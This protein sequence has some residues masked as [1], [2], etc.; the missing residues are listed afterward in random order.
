[1]KKFR[2]VVLL[3]VA[4]FSIFALVGCGNN[5]SKEKTVKIGIMTSDAPIWEPIKTKLAK[6]NINLKITEF[7]DFNQPNQALSQGELDIN[8]FQHKYFLNNWNK[9]HNTNLV[10]IGTTVIAPLRVYS[11]K[12]KSIN[13]LKSGDK[14]TIPNDA[15]NE[16]RAL[17]LLETAGL[18]KLKK[19]ALPTVKDISQYN[20][21]ITITPLDAAQ[22][23][24]SLND[25]TAAVVN[26]T[27]AASA[28]LPS[29][30]VIYKE[31]ITKKSDQWLNIIATDKKNK[32]NPTFKKVVK[33]Y[34]SKDNAKNIKK[35]YKGTT[36]PAWDLKL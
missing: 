18:I 31:K 32:D 23:A 13:D 25:A 35:T 9:T 1:M 2:S 5:S 36:L 11:T 24:H 8:A 19:A 4:A 29:N 33:A 17:Q 30:E 16:G 14:V 6:E 34:Q 28:N 15:T 26:N 21:K 3:V 27:I 7:N 10:S 12:I 22:T 20:K